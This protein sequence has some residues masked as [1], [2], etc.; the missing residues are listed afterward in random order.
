MD[1]HKRPAWLREA[2]TVASVAEDAPE[3]KDDDEIIDV[4]LFE[5]PDAN[6][7]IWEGNQTAMNATQLSNKHESEWEQLDMMKRQLAAQVE[8][9]QKAH[10]EQLKELQNSQAERLALIEKDLSTRHAE[11]QET[12]ASAISASRGNACFS[13]DGKCNPIPVCFSAEV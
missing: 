6:P 7:E 4:N 5:M 10:A 13:D 3:E 11:Q 12:I 2:A 9:L 1:V 8:Q